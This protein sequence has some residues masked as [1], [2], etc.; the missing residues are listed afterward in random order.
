MFSFLCFA[1]CI[2]NQEPDITEIYVDELLKAWN[3]KERL[4]D[5][6]HP[7]SVAYLLEY[8]NTTTSF[9]ARPVDKV[10]NLKA[11]EVG[12]SDPIVIEE[13]VTPCLF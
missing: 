5:G 6:K 1:V 9:I 12:L 3:I 13:G 7:R 11:P 2:K 4:L 10:P 8:K